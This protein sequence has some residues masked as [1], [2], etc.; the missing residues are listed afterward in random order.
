MKKE[1][2][3]NEIQTE[4]FMNCII[5]LIIINNSNQN[6]NN[7]NFSLDDNE[8]IFKILFRYVTA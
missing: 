5:L 6:I 2:K 4:F 7:K 3:V 1:R 8:S